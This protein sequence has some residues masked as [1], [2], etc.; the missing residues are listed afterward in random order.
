MDETFPRFRLNVTAVGFVRI[1]A[2]L[3]LFK[4]GVKGVKL[5]P[6]YVISL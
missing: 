5:M 1:L 2:S 6:S 3:W 4:G